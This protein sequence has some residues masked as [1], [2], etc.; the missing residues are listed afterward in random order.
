[1]PQR[2][3]QLRTALSRELA[4]RVL[5]DPV[6]KDAVLAPEVSIL[7]GVGVGDGPVGRHIGFVGVLEAVRRK[8][9]GQAQEA[10][11]MYVRS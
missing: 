1:M 2:H 10:Q 5:R 7:V 6:P 3:K 8:A 11:A 4:I 9:G